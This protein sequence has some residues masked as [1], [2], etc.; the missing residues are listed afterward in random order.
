M[1]GW[2]GSV[3]QE[4]GKELTSESNKFYPAKGVVFY[5]GQKPCP[6]FPLSWHTGGVQ[7]ISVS[8]MNKPRE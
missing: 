8:W 5:E 7:W 4:L 3:G 1:S 2:W 6:H